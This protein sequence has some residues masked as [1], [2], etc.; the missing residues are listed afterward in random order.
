M[1]LHNRKFNISFL[2]LD[3]IDNILQD[4]LT[5]CFDNI[6]ETAN[7]ALFSEIVYVFMSEVFIVGWKRGEYGPPR[8]ARWIN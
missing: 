7:E 1:H 5:S 3:R 6:S 4:F 2:R 8:V